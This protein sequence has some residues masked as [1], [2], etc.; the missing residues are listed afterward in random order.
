[1]EEIADAVLAA[2]ERWLSGPALGEAL[3]PKL[4]LKPPYIR[5]YLSRA[6]N[7]GASGALAWC[8]L[9]EDSLD[10]GGVAKPSALYFTAGQMKFVTMARTIL[11]EVTEAEIVDD[12]ARPWRYHSERGSLMWDSVDDRDHALSAADPTDK[13]RNPKLTNPGAE[14]LAII[15]LSRYPCFAA[16]QG[17][18]TQGCSGSWKR[19]LFVWPLWSAPAT[20]RAVGSLLAQVVAPEGSERRR[21]DWYRSWGIS[22]V[23]QSQVRRSSQGGYGTFG[24]PRVVWQRE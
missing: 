23:M 15:G 17:T 18:L 7:A 20:A 8:L 12:I 3:D 22:R 5:E 10:K 19:G 4:K 16:P 1:M 13:S 2:S 6:R 9:A 14:A 11:S 21:G 24:P